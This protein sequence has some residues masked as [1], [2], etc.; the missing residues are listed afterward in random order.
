MSCVVNDSCP[1]SLSLIAA[2]HDDWI[3]QRA[4]ALLEQRVFKAGPALHSLDAVHDY[5]RLKLAAEPN[6]MF[7]V[8]FLNY[9]HEVLA[10]EPLFRGSIGQ[11]KVYPR[12]VAQRALALNASGVILAHQHPSGLT[13]PSA[14]DRALTK[15]LEKALALVDVRVVDHLVIGKGKPF[16][17]VEAGLL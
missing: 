7:A 13:E 3:I 14:D 16:S 2:Q 12:V 9:H 5:L 8:V 4:I 10:Y 6:E 17:F 1:E 11:S 15:R